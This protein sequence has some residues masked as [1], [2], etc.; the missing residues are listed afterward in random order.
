MSASITLVD[1]GLRDGLQSIGPVVPTSGKIALLEGL[2]AA[3]VRRVEATAFVS[4]KAVPQMADAADVL[5]AAQALEGM[6]AQVLVPTLRHAERALAAGADHIAFVFSVSPAHNQSNVR[7]TPAQSLEDFAQIA[8]QL[9]AGTRVRLN[10]ATA[11]DCPFNGPVAPADTLALMAEAISIAPDA[12]ICPCDTTGRVT[13]DRIAA[14]F[15][16]AIRRFPQVSRWAYHG[17][18][19]YG[20]GTANVAAALSAGIT[21]IDAS[22]GGLG[23]CP[24]APGA[25]GNVATEDVVWMLDQMGATTGIDLPQLVAVARLAAAIPG[26]IAGGRVRDAISAALCR[27]SKAVA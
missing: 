23:G 6:D 14:L 8:A 12:E 5:A 22:I 21:T 10:M 19:T 7:R 25:T 17:H 2:Y 20:M 15:E 26:A 24:F 1:V 13:P 9:P 3:G 11:F 4:E 27:P 16:A 18:D